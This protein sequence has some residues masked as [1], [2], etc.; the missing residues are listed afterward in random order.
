[1]TLNSDFVNVG[2]D[3]IYLDA[4]ATTPPTIDVIN[5]VREIQFSAWG[6]PSSLH[7]QGL[8]AAEVMERSR[9][10]IAMILHAQSNELVFTSGAT[11]S[12]HL[13]LL[14]LAMSRPAKR[15]VISSVEHPAVNAVANKLNLMGWEV[16]RW[17][18]NE[19][20]LVRLDLMDQMLS[21]P[22]D[23][24]SV[25]WGQSEIGTIQPI[26]EIGSRC[27]EKSILFHT[28]ATQVLSQGY[29][30]WSDLPVDLLSASAHKFQGPRGIGLLCIRE[31]LL[32]KISSLLGGGGQENGLRSGTESVALIA[33]ME[34]ALKQLDVN[35]ILNGYSDN[36]TNNKF[37]KIVELRDCLRNNLSSLNGIYF[38][39]DPIDRL[40]HHI[41]MLIASKTGQPLSGRAIVRELSRHGI[42]ASSGSACRSSHN[43]NSD[44][45][46]A[47]GIST[48]W[49]QSGLRFSLGPWLTSDQIDLVPEKLSRAREAVVASL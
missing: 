1:M 40:P 35:P 38:T 4:S 41:S 8:L 2:V 11:E 3:N 45:L 6:N 13:A 16:I 20:G 34:V 19:H 31:N 42:S 32:S 22:T 46:E 30:K 49:L 9:Q 25:I 21:S 10:S 5:R 39:G 12:I 43:S 15:L 23:I 27:R 28:D 26:F 37:L 17:P 29:I 18:V 7:S 44:V 24:V 33:G 36:S 48:P 47:I 14:G